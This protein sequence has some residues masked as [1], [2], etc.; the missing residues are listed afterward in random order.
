[1]LVING[2]R[3]LNWKYILFKL[4]GFSDGKNHFREITTEVYNCIVS[5]V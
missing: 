5:A 1:M 2:S 4:Q 3:A